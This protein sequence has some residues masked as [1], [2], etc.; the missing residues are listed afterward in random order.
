MSKRPEPEQEHEYCC[1]FPFPRDSNVGM[2]LYVGHIPTRTLRMESLYEYSV[3]WTQFEDSLFL[4]SI[5][6]YDF[7]CLRLGAGGLRETSVLPAL[8]V[9]PTALVAIPGRRVL[10]ATVQGFRLYSADERAWSRFSTGGESAAQQ[11]SETKGAAAVDQRFV[12]FFAGSG[13]SKRLDLCDPEGGLERCDSAEAPAN[14]PWSSPVLASPFELVQWDDEGTRR[15][16]AATGKQFIETERRCEEQRVAR[17]R[18]GVVRRGWIYGFVRG[19]LCAVSLKSWETRV[20]CCIQG[21]DASD[22]R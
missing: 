8:S 9:Y 5:F 16:D 1:G 7:R 22:N 10:A 18:C 19:K 14:R 15:V 6:H 2:T 12:Y 4:E 21:D 17:V 3:A 13:S 20:L 11:L